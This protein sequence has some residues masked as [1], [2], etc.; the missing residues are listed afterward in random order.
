MMIECCSQERTWLPYYGLIA[1]RFCMMHRRWQGAFT[2]CFETNYNTIHRCVGTPLLFALERL[3]SHPSN[4]R[5]KG[6]GKFSRGET[7]IDRCSCYWSTTATKL[8]RHAFQ[9]STS[10][11]LLCMSL[12]DHFSTLARAVKFIFFKTRRQ[13]IGRT[14]AMMQPSTLNL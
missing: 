5:R 9:K 6:E 11:T 8:C 3:S 1:Q 10:H 2:E 14:Y 4:T 12:D 13:D 7:E